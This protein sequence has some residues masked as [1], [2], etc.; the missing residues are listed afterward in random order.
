MISINFMILATI[1][2]MV[3]TNCYIPHAL[4][5]ILLLLYLLVF[6]A[7]NSATIWNNLTGVYM[8]VLSQVKIEE[9]YFLNIYVAV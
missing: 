1:N 7:R 8:I 4:C 3:P 2:Y 5:Y 9:C 6:T